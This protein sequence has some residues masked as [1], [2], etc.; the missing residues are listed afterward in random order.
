MKIIISHDIDHLSVREHLFKDIVIE[1][2]ILWTLI[3]F[4]KRKIPYKLM[5][6]KIISLFKK[7]GW[8]NINELLEYDKKNE[9]R[10]TFFVAVRNGRRINYSIENAVKTIKMIMN[11]GFEVGVHGIAY[12]NY[13]DIKEEYDIFKK[14]SELESFGIRIHYLKNKENTFK[15]LSDAGYLFDST[16]YSDK[17]EQIYTI[18][19]IREV[20]FHFMDTL[21]FDPLKNFSLFDI[22]KRTID[23]LKRFIDQKKDYFCIIFHQRY[24]GNDFPEQ[25]E[26]YKWFIEYCKKMNYEFIDFKTLIKK[27]L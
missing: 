7:N 25:K 1:K 8:N 13:N 20:P 24:F 3:E 12:K 19:G 18:S 4:I 9:I 5:I 17:S 10:S 22:K 27:C 2:Y 14:I 21:Y 23:L 26:W 6:K 16:I 15:L 11:Y